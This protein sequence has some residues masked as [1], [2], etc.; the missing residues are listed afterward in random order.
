MLKELI[1]ND[2]L[3]VGNIARAVNL[4]QGTVTQIIIR[5][6]NRGYVVRS[7]DSADRRRVLVTSTEKGH[8]ILDNSP[9]L[10]HES[11]VKKFSGLDDWEQNMILSSLQR[12]AVMMN[13]EHLEA[14]PI[15]SPGSTLT[16]E[17]IKETQQAV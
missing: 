12:M 10:L 3:T 13:A 8:R 4:S 9:S 1:K 5:L 2:S 17:T 16:S 6:E 14:A 15:I 7:K 11:F